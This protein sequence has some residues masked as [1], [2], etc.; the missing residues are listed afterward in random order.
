MT[1][2]S[3][4]VA[5]VFVALAMSAFMAL[6]T[7]VERRTGNSGWIDVVWTFGLGLTGI[8]G[9]LLPFGAGPMSRRFVV[10]G[11]ALAWALRLGLHIVNPTSMYWPPV[12]LRQWTAIV[13]WPF[14]RALTAPAS[15]GS[16]K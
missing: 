1:I 3:F 15:N 5:V 16:C 4:I 12:V 8:A 10:A 14:R 2:A 7:M 13:L 9:A 6:A 11:L